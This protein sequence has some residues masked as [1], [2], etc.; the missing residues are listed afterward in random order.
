MRPL[1]PIF[2][3]GIFIAAA[4]VVVIVVVVQGDD[5]QTA[6]AAT[7]TTVAST[8]TTTIPPTPAEAAAAQRVQTEM[9]DDGQTA[10]VSGYRGT[11]RVDY[12][13]KPQ[14]DLIVAYDYAALKTDFSGEATRPTDATEGERSDVSHTVTFGILRPFF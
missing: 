5:S 11:A 12:H 8:T 14:W 6:D 2:F 7:P 9:L 10:D 1:P 4:L 3:A 13:W